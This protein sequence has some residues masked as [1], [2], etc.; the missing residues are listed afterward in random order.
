MAYDI[1]DAKQFLIGGFISIIVFFAIRG[2]NPFFFNP[3]IGLFITIILFWIYYNGFKMRNKQLHFAVN[4]LLA[5]AISSTV[6]VIFE[7]IKTEQIFTFQ[8]FGTLAI[9]GVWIAFPSGLLYDRYNL[10]NPMRRN[11]IRGK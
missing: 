11:Y 10:E 5:F 6:A 4:I 1:K 8:I 3:K 9:V 2:G 7:L